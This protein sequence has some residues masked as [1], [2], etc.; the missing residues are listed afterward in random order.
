MSKDKDYMLFALEL[1]I[2][3][4]HYEGF[5]GKDKF[6]WFGVAYLV[7]LLLLFILISIVTLPMAIIF[8]V[9]LL[10]SANILTCIFHIGLLLSGRKGLVYYEEELDGNVL[11][12]E[13]GINKP[14]NCLHKSKTD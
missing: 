14:R 8:S 6:L 13:S 12:I 7:P 4:R 5:D 9:P 1:K 11:N 3:D 2:T 10:G